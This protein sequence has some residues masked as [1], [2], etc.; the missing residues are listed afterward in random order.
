MQNVLQLVL[1]TLHRHC[2]RKQRTGWSTFKTLSALPVISF[3][4]C[5]LQAFESEFNAAAEAAG[6]RLRKLDKKA[7]RGRVAEQQRAW[8]AQLVAEEDP[9]AALL[10]LVP[11]LLARQQGR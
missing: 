4:L 11:C 7:E 9:S 8:Q 3:A 10:L 2:C 6:L 1:C 5:A